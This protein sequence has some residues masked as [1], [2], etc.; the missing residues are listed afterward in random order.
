[1]QQVVTKLGMIHILVNN[2]GITRDVALHNMRVEQWRAVIDVDL[3]GCFNMCKAV[4]D[5]RCANG[6]LV[7]S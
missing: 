2:A 6:V 4:I 7:G 1:V 5:N 3:G